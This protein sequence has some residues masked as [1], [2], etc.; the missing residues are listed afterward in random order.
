MPR[1]QDEHLDDSP[2]EIDEEPSRSLIE[3]TW[4]RV[5]LVFLGVA[6]V[7]AIALPYVVD[8][9]SPPAKPPIVAKPAAPPASPPAQAPAPAPPP[10]TTQSAPPVTAP[11]PS[12][13]AEKSLA[14]PQASSPAVAT[15]TPD[16]PKVASA[17]VGDYWV[18]V[19]AFRDPETAR[20]LAASLRSA[21]YNVA[22]LTATT[23]PSAAREPAPARISAPAASAPSAPP[24]PAPSPRSSA[25]S[26][27]IHVSGAASADLSAKLIAKGLSVDTAGDGVV[28]RP[29]LPLRDAIALSKELASDGFKVQVKRARGA[30]GTSPPIGASPPLPVQ[31][32]ASKPSAAPSPATSGDA[33]ETLH[34][35]RVGGFADR[36]AAVA[37][38]HELEAKGYKP[39]ITRG[40]D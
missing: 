1:S 3:T 11:A 12:K 35:V 40:R 39:F 14:K 30:D 16:T 26:Y 27:D 10:A 2:D 38:M 19:G 8:Y 32:S 25:D 4:F 36:A 7:A 37:A 29:S 18:Q 28:V 23:A 22:E 6:G 5:V 9:V 33:R 24:P 13:P 17:A 21:G 20:R 15:K 34:R 31:P